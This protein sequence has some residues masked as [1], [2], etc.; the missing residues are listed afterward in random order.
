MD[1]SDYIT[2]VRSVSQVTE[3]EVSN[4]TVEVF[5]KQNGHLLLSFPIYSVVG[6]SVWLPY[7]YYDTNFT[8]RD[9]LGVDVTTSITL[10][11][12]ET[13]EINIDNTKMLTGAHL[14]FTGTF[15]DLYSAT[16]QVLEYAVASTASDSGDIVEVRDQ[17]STIKYDSS[18]SASSTRLM[19]AAQFRGMG[20]AVHQ[21]STRTDM[22]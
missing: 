13:G 17:G 3:D 10:V 8:V 20:F 14:F 16:A 19:R 6:G 7:A 12:K 1:F 22:I 18:N 5:I 11:N 21:N 2:L 15:Y 4:D 9:G